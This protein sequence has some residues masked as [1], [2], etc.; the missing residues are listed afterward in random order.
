MRCYNTTTVVW[1]INR[2]QFHFATM[3]DQRCGTPI[4][5]VH[6]GGAFVL[7]GDGRVQFLAQTI[8]LNTFKDLVDRND[9]RVVDIP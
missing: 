4:Q 7:F 2:K 5:S 1:P 6:T 8:A 9:G 3:G